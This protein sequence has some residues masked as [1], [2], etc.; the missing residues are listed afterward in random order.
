[1]PRL[2]HN[3]YCMHR[4][5]L[6]DAWLDHYTAY[7]AFSQNEQ[8]D[9]HRFFAPTKRLTNNELRQYRK[10]K[11]LEDPSLPH[12]AGKLMTRFYDAYHEV[13][14][15]KTLARKVPAQSR[16]KST[17]DMNIVVRSVVNPEPD[18]EELI[19]RAIAV[20]KDQDR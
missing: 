16:V 10:A 12:R 18:F 8:W 3:Q 15:A 11:T 6:L 13:M 2:T 9:L 1:M 5:F 17:R 7:N 14:H 4:S 19:R 20:L